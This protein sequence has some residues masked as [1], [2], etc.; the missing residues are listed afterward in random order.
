MSRNLIIE[1]VFITI[2]KRSGSHHCD[3]DRSEYLHGFTLCIVDSCDKN[4]GI[5]TRLIFLV[6]EA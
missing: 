4:M 3:E 2:F 5:L 1:C 6:I